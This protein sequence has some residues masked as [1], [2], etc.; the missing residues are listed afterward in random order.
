MYTDWAALSTDFRN[1]WRARS[2]I[3]SPTSSIVLGPG[4]IRVIDVFGTWKAP[5][6]YSETWPSVTS[7]FV[8]LS[9]S[10][11]AFVVAQPAAPRRAIR[12]KTGNLERLILAVF[13][14]PPC[15][16]RNFFEHVPDDDRVHGEDLDFHAFCLLKFLEINDRSRGQFAQRMALALVFVGLDPP[17]GLR[18]D[19]PR[20]VIREQLGR[21]SGAIHFDQRPVFAPAKFVNSA[22]E[23]VR[24]GSGFPAS[25]K[26]GAGGRH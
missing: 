2:P 21:Q 11:F 9:G 13:I 12:R 23:K 15:I 4:G 24:A 16:S 10:S 18:E 26:R 25:D 20:T 17:L 7:F 22:R 19:Q 14:L 3:S 5:F 6:L 1:D 8:Y